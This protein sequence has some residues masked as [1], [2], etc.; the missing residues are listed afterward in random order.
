MKVS[1]PR[2]SLFRNLSFVWLVPLV[3]LGV[4]LG[5]AWQN[6]ADRGTLIE[7]AFR[8]ASGVV[9]GETTLRYRDVVVGTVEDVRFTSDLGQVLVYVRVDNDVAPFIDDEAT[10]WVVRPEVSAR[11]ISGLSTVLSGVYI[12]G[13]WDNMPDRKSVV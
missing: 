12:E 5:I 8:N 10:F 4:S 6:Y 9:A 13:A 7:I 11:G 3:A 2:K 1:A